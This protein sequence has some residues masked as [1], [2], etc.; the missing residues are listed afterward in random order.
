MGIFMNPAEFTA[1]QTGSED[2]RAQGKWGPRYVTWARLT[3]T[4]SSQSYFHFNTHWCVH[5]GNGHT[6]GGSKRKQGAVNMLETIQ[7]VAGSSPTI[8]TGDFN[9]GIGASGVQH[10]RNNGFDVAR[11]EWVDAILYSRSHWRL[12][13]VDTGSKSGSDHHPILAE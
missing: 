6:C 2:I 7:R 5:N 4:G 13:H 10:L 12:G 3:H 11:H 1:S 8:I 9:E